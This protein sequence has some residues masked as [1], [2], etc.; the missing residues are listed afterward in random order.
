LSNDEY[1]ILAGKIYYEKL[2][3]RLKNYSIP[4]KGVSLFNSP[5]FLKDLISKEQSIT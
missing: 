4:L 2:L 5:G 3:P 1:V